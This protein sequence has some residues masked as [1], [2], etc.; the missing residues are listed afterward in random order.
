MRTP[1]E[2]FNGPAAPATER[3]DKRTARDAWSLD[4]RG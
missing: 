1:N 3:E 4:E 2:R